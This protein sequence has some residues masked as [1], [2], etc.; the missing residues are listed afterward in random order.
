MAKWDRRISL[1]VFRIRNGI[2]APRAIFKNIT[3]LT[4]LTVRAGRTRVGTLYIEPSHSRPPAWISFF[5]GAISRIPDNL[6]NA[7]TKGVLLVRRPAGRFAIAFGLG[8][9]LMKPGCWDEGFGLRTTLNSIDAD[10][11]LSIDKHTFDAIAAH[12]KSVATRPAAADQFG[13]D[14]QRD[15]LAAVTGV[16]RDQSLGIRMAG[17]E[18]LNVRVPIAVGDLPTQL[19]KYQQRFESNDYQTRFMWID[20]IRDVRDEATQE[21]LTN[22]LVAALRN[23]HHQSIYLA[24]PEP[25]E[26]AD[27][28]GFRY[29]MT[30]DEKDDLA[31]A[32]FL[33]VLGDR[34]SITR[35]KLGRSLFCIGKDNDTVI[36]EWPAWKCMN[37]EADLRGQRYVLSGGHWYR[38]SNDFM[39]EI[40]A[41]VG[42]I[43]TAAVALPDYDH[44]DERAYNI[45]VA[46]A[47]AGH[48]AN[49]DR[50]DIPFGGGASKIEFC[51]LYSGH[52]QLIHVKRYAG[53]SP[54][55]HLFSQ[56][57][58]AGKLWLRDAAFRGEVNRRLPATH[59]LAN[60]AQNPEA[61]AFEIVYGIVIGSPRPLSE[62][63]PFFSRVTLVTAHEELTLYGFR[64]SALKIPN[65]RA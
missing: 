2:T 44:D 12:T 26:W 30:G 15:L 22:Q 5:E 37:Y 13:I 54:L 52:R 50:K 51:D 65:T 63:L 61:T 6:W 46:T 40:N 43:P 34:H 3:S 17:R 14:I 41:K 49:M 25:I 62:A 36:H 32:D 39:A 48:L 7:N 21:R 16:P 53:S 64:V 33:D 9:F 10:R 11:I 57:V 58:V 38:I 29:S 35:P 31:L 59:R 23:G 47:S 20:K 27:V 18:A 4:A 55:S 28:S 45:A 1:N 19:D 56:G 24:V 8:R 60:P 42:Q